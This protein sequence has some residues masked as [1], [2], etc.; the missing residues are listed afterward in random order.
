ME[1]SVDFITG[2]PHVGFDS[3]LH[4][5]SCLTQATGN[6]NEATFWQE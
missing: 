6:K 1:V 5:G 2:V 3:E 4:D